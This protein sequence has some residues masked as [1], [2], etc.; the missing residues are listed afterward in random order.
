MIKHQADL[1]LDA[2]ERGTVVNVGG[3]HAQKRRLKG[4]D[5]EWLGDYLVHE[6]AAAGG[7]VV[8]LDVGVAQIVSDFEPVQFPDWDVRD[9]SPDNELFRVMAE[10]WPGKVVFLPLDDPVFS[11]GRVPMNFEGEIYVGAPRRTY[12]VFVEPPLAHRVPLP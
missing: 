2:R 12:D 1:R 3:N 4:T 7:S 6:S 11:A 5:Q 9:A 10:T 8:I